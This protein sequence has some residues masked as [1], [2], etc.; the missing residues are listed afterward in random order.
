MK[1]MRAVLLSSAG[2]GLL[3]TACVADAQNPS[4]PERQSITTPQAQ[5]QGGQQRSQS[6][7]VAQQSTADEGAARRAPAP[8]PEEKTSV[9]HHSARI[10]AQQINYTSTAGTHIIKAEDGTPKASFFYVAYTKDGVS[11]VAERPIAICYNGGPGSLALHAY[12]FW[13]KARGADGR[14]TLHAGSVQDR[15]Q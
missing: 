2:L 5:A 9:T 15:G 11:D 4:Q 12:G 1:K 7:P 10:G 14:W 8:P 13:T 6:A 3:F